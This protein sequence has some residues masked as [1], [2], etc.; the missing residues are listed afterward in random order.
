MLLVNLLLAL[1]WATLTGNMSVKN[2]GLGFLLGYV[3][4]FISRNALGTR[5][6]SIRVYRAVAFLFFFMWELLVANLRVALDVISPG[7]RLRPALLAIPLDA[8]TNAEITTLANLITLTPG[9]MTLD[10]ST[11]KRV[12]YIH[13]MHV[14]DP[15]GARRHIK[16][17]ERKLLEVLR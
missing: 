14:R 4:L 11:D 12:L 3:V 16:L 9:T 10:V 7:T 17:L 6:Y 5:L 13:D 2:L 15:D 8:T 1:V